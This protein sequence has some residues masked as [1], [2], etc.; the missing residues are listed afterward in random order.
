MK[1]FYQLF[2]AFL[3]LILVILGITGVVFTQFN[4]RS[5]EENNYRQ[6]ARY[7][8]SV[9]Q[10][11]EDYQNDPYLGAGTLNEQIVR[12]MQL[13]EQVLKS[14]QV[15]FIFIDLARKAEYPNLNQTQ[16]DKLLS[17]EE[18]AALKRQGKLQKHGELRKTLSHDLVGEK[19]ATSYV[20]Q[21]LYEQNSGRAVGVLGVTQDAQ[22][23]TDNAT[24]ILANLGKGFVIAAL[25]SLV[26]SY[27]LAQK[28]ARKIKTFNQAIQKIAAGDFDIQLT[29]ADSENEFEQLTRSFNQMAVS[30]K[31][32]QEEIARQEELRKQFMA[33]ASHEM[34]T[35]LTTIKGLL[36]GLK[37]NAIPAAQ[38]KNAVGL[39]EKETDRMIRL[40]KENLDYERIR[41][42]QIMIEPQVF[43]ATEVIR[44]ICQQ[45]KT[46][47]AA[48]GDEL[49]LATAEPVELYADYDRFMQIIV[50]IVQNAIQFTQ[51][52]TITLR[53]FQT[54]TEVGITIQDTGIGMAPEQVKNIWERYY[55]VDPSRTNKK[56]A[57]SG[58][59]LSIVQ[60]LMNLHHG[61][62]EVKSQLGVGTQ[63]T[64]YFPKQ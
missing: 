11:Q 9:L 33:D 17:A 12:A 19:K 14:Q 53:L 31:N 13:T 47:A 23:I 22:N 48:E 36:E 16:V 54:E 1:Y 52:G 4:Q 8:N 20:F 24:S 26:V 10:M 5:L 32:S 45:L 25:I 58:L 7:G 62:V 28:Q 56:Y 39:M 59:G 27:F 40:I 30:L 35:P 15:H 64:L 55:K 29:E 50:N 42:N 63:F 61:R 44:Q 3:L 37:Y 34:K 38:Q 41:A 46:K 51:N 57:E 18:Y 43:D 21:L 2:F 6:L 60:Q 49:V